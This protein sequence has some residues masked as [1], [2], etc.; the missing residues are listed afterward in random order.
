VTTGC[1]NASHPVTA[2]STRGDGQSKVP[3][4]TGIAIQ[5]YSAM[6]QDSPTQH[7]RA[8]DCTR[9]AKQILEETQ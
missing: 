3:G 8:W 1:T 9:D 5:A 7:G 4:S 6:R 2:I